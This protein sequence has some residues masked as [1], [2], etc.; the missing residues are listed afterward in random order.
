M[1]DR[2]A[3]RLVSS[4]RRPTPRG[5]TRASRARG[6]RRRVQS[7]SVY[8]GYRTGNVVCANRVDGEIAGF[9]IGLYPA[10]DNVVTCDNAAPGAAAGLV[11]DTGAPGDCAG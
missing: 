11:G 3:C 7:H 6:V 1:I 4:G 10:L 9:G 8:E 5:P 2:L